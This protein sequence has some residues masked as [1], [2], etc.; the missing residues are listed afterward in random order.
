[1]P[2]TE[3]VPA[4]SA[5]PRGSCRRTRSRACSARC[6][7]RARRSTTS[8]C[9]SEWVDQPVGQD[10]GMAIEESQSLLLEMMVGRSRAFVSFPAAAAREALRRGGA[11]V[12][13]GK[14]LPPP[15]PG[16]ARTEPHGRRRAHLPDPHLDALR[17]RAAAAD[18]RARGQGPARGLEFAVGGPA[19]ARAGERPRGLPA[20]HPL[21]D[22]LVRALP[23][24]RRRRRDRR[25]AL[26]DDPRAAARASRRKSRRASSAACWRGCAS[27]CTPWAR[28]SA[29][30][31][32]CSTRPAAR[33]PRRRSCVTWSAS[34]SRNPRMRA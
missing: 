3:G 25:P 24:V 1:M 17:A 34:T 15:E 22:R 28:A 6:T 13:R 31:S 4:T 27:A 2:F 7:R 14:S 20:G 30:R 21:G 32:S 12:D 16:R 11:R 26:G 8:A 9:P 5:S 10:R 19:R 18:G 33:C 23:V 29:C